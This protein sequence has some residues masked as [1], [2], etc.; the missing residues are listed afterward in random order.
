MIEKSRLILP[1]YLNENI[2]MDMLAIIEDGFSM[3]SEISSSSIAAT[4]R[5]E[6]TKASFSTSDLLGKLLKIELGAE[7]NKNSG[8][9]NSINSK[10]EKI[11]TSTSLLSK[12]RSKLV[13]L[14]LL[15]SISGSVK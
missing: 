3:V 7:L 8:D 13:E 10:T 6:N 2:V 1:V 5:N 15:T 4:S 11:H 9:E 12:F 14:E